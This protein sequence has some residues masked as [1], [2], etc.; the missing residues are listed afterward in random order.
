MLTARTAAEVPNNSK[1]GHPATACCRTHSR[2]AGSQPSPYAHLT[3]RSSEGTQNTAATAPPLKAGGTL[4][5]IG[6]T[7]LGSFQNSGFSVQVPGPVQQ[8]DQVSL[9]K[10]L[11]KSVIFCSAPRVKFVKQISVTGSFLAMLYT[12]GGMRQPSDAM[13]QSCIGNA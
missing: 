3:A 10:Y 6:L 9:S 12:L 2:R 13:S 5:H 11:H 1:L 4:P 8:T 7:H